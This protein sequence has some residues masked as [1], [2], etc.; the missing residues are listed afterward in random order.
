MK[1]R[2]AINILCATCAVT[3]AT[4][5]SDDE[6]QSTGNEVTFS[7]R[8][9]DS[10]P[11]SRAMYHSY[12]ASSGNTVAVSDGTETKKY[13]ATNISSN[14]KAD[15]V[16]ASGVTPFYWNKSG[17]AF[18]AWLKYTYTTTHPSGQVHTMH[19]SYDTFAD[20]DQDVFAYASG[21]YTRTNNAMTFYQQTARVTFQL[22]IDTKENAFSSAKDDITGLTVGSTGL[23]TKAKWTKPAAGENYGKWDSYSTTAVIT[24]PKGESTEEFTRFKIMALPRNYTG[25][26]GI[27]ITTTNGNYTFRLPATQTNWQAGTH[28]LYKLTLHAGF[29]ELTDVKVTLDNYSENTDDLWQ[30]VDPTVNG[31]VIDYTEGTG[32]YK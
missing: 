17:N 19:T 15:L 31:T 24:A 9:S 14:V 10:E 3:M 25:G 1:L 12:W 4:G 23:Y 8:V 5:C 16:P 29:V 32:L 21:T 7:A 30:S 28:Y 18:D 26:V 6:L 11:T 27:N 13:Q 2:N 20:L 22:Y